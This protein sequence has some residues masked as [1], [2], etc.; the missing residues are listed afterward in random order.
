MASPRRT[1]P[2]IWT[3]STSSRA[4]SRGNSPFLTVALFRPPSWRR[5]PGRRKTTSAPKRNW[6]S[7]PRYK[8]FSKSIYNSEVNHVK[9][10][11]KKNWKNKQK[12]KTSSNYF[13]FHLFIISWCINSL[14]SIKKTK[15]INYWP[16][17]VCTSKVHSMFCPLSE[18]QPSRSGAIRRRG[19]HGRRHGITLRG[20]A[21]LLN[22]Q[23]HEATHRT[24]PKTDMGKREKPNR[25]LTPFLRKIYSLHFL[26]NKSNT[27]VRLNNSKQLTSRATYE[28][29]ADII[30]LKTRPGTAIKPE[31]LIEWKKGKSE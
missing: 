20:E 3:R 10:N 26:V 17:T 5:G 21:C 25:H 2:S 7:G 13:F 9:R 30:Q 18:Q 12:L 6:L 4:R 8:L 29:I 28:T 14:I 19:R 15:I 24:N 16:I 23:A 31:M 22:R 11:N 27:L 1:P